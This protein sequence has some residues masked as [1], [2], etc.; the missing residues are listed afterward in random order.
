VT[1]GRTDSRRIS[2]LQQ[3]Q[4]L[5]SL[6]C[7]HA[8]KNWRTFGLSAIFG[9]KYMIRGARLLLCPLQ[10]GPV[11]TKSPTFVSYEEV[12]RVCVGRRMRRRVYSGR[13]GDFDATSVWHVDVSDPLRSAADVRLPAG[14][15][16]SHDGQAP[17]ERRRRRRRTGTG[18]AVNDA[19]ATWRWRHRRGEVV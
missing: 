8:G 5:Q 4:R 15:H 1:D 3:H 9:S 19:T 14:S 2:L 17:A 18:N 12:S 10:C 11:W 16:V 7:Y 6:L 13:H